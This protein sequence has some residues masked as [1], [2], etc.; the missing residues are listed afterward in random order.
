M[1]QQDAIGRYITAIK[2]AALAEREVEAATKHLIE[3]APFKIGDKVL[4]CYQTVLIPGFVTEV[5]IRPY[6]IGLGD[7][8]LFY[9]VVRRPTKAGA[10][11]DRT[12][13]MS[14][15]ASAEDLQP[16]VEK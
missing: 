6:R 15:H 8:D 9:F 13:V 14:H 16:F 4:F 12:M 11:S 7:N 5:N 3:N 10:F 2:A 1:T